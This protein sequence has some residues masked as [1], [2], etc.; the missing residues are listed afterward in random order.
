M[1]SQHAGFD[2]PHAA[3]R[4]KQHRW[5][6]TGGVHAPSIHCRLLLII[7][8][9]V[10]S[11]RGLLDA[12]PPADGSQIHM[13]LCL[14]LRDFVPPEASGRDAAATAAVSDM[15]R[16]QEL[17][18]FLFSC[19][20]STSR[21]S[22]GGVGKGASAWAGQHRP[23]AW[24]SLPEPAAQGLEHNVVTWSLMCV[25]APVLERLELA[26]AFRVVEMPM[27]ACL[28]DMESWG[29]RMDTQQLLQCRRVVEDRMEALQQV[30]VWLRD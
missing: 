30:R 18:S 10:S 22:A 12:D 13:A 27:V 21:R 6:R 8:T 19:V 23:A 20:G 29:V 11:G 25:L 24:R 15:D 28:Q 14:G 7:P 9:V 16:A 17:L 5:P 3:V 26:V 4:G 1:E 2:V